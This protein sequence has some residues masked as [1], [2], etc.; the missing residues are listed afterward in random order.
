MP[1]M[2]RSASLNEEFSFSFCIKIPALPTKEKKK[3]ED[4]KLGNKITCKLMR[5]T[6]A[7]K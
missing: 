6:K 1:K 7:L 4:E 5:G 2:T 3:K